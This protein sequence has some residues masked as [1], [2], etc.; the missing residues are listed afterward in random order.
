MLHVRDTEGN[1][2]PRQ[3]AQ[4]SADPERANV[5]SRL[6]VGRVLS[7]VEVLVV[8]EGCA[9]R[10]DLV[11]L[12]VESVNNRTAAKRASG[13]AGGSTESVHLDGCHTKAGRRR[14]SQLSSTTEPQRQET[15][16]RVKRFAK[17][18]FRSTWAA[19]LQLPMSTC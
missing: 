6:Q 3:H 10:S 11:R 12:R 4:A 15:A 16:L 8:D 19:A 18:R 17:E 9:L 13:R 7:A 2:A 5:A 14:V 1:L